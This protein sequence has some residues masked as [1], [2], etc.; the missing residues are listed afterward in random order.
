MPV[1]LHPRPAEM[2]DYQG[3]R[4]LMQESCYI[5][6][7][8]DWRHPLDLLGQQPYWVIENNRGEIVAALA[9]PPYPPGTAWINFFAANSITRPEQVWSLLLENALENC[10]SPGIQ[11]L[12]VLP[13]QPWFIRFLP[14]HHFSH[15]QDVVML[16]WNDELP[17]DKNTEEQRPFI[18]PMKQEDL[19]AVLTL[20]N[21]SFSPLWQLSGDSLKAAYQDSVYARVFILD[22]RVTGYLIANL[23]HLG[24]HISRLAVSRLHRA[25]GIGS[26]LV[27]D[28]LSYFLKIGIKKV[29][30]NTQDDN[31]ASL[32]LYRA[33]NFRLT[34]EK[35]PVFIYSA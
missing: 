8:L 4:I 5:H 24:G 15:S 29:T 30:V 16:E 7:H 9:C 25:R 22:G 33:A 2:G 12:A 28:A 13:T 10:P 31:E 20:D 21:Q 6:R 32:A 17:A 35:V 34:G 19:P 18:R 11:N 1:T 26:C 27:L 14:D 3:I 23:T